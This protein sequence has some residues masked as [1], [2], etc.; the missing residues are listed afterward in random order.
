MELTLKKYLL[1][2]IISICTLTGYGQSLVGTTGLLY[3]PTADMQKDK[4]VLIGGNYLN[5]H[6]M[7]NHFHSKEVDYTFN[8]YINITFFPWL[9]IGYT[10][11]LVHADHGSDYFPKHVWGTFPNQDRSF[12]GRI[13]LWKEGWWKE[14]TPQIVVGIDDAGT[15]EDHGGGEIISGNTSSSNNYMT[16]YYAA[17]SKHHHFKGIGEVGLHVSY[18]KGKAK[19]IPEY[20]GIGAGINFQPIFDNGNFYHRI[21]NGFNLM[22]EYDARTVN[23]GFNY[24]FIKDLINITCAWNDCQHFSG[25]ILFKIHLK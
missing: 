21:L 19:G 6:H 22:A 9:E 1:S 20:E 18:M 5:T 23:L 12:Y 25:G 16:R 10:C 24:A 11:T 15:H 4:T 3:M 13:R 7:S 17:V 14:W 8:Y 2:A